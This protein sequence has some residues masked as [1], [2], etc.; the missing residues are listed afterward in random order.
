MNTVMHQGAREAAWQHSYC[1]ATAFVFHGLLLTGL[2]CGRADTELAQLQQQVNDQ[3][4]T[5]MESVQ[6][7]E[8]TFQV[9][10]TNCLHAWFAAEEQL[11][12]A[13]YCIML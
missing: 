7:E 12:I 5:A 13:K 9:M 8:E 6:A 4:Q 1:G 11:V 10:K 3:T 2:A